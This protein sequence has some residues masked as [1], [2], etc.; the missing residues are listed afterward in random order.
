[1]YKKTEPEMEKARIIKTVRTI[2]RLKHSLAADEEIN[3]ILPEKLS[4]F[5]IALQSGQLKQLS[6]GLDDLLNED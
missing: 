4:D 6:I 5:D 3:N 2:V 1:M